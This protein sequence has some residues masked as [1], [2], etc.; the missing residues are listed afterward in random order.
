MKESL[1]ELLI[2]LWKQFWKKYKKIERN[3]WTFFFVSKENR[4]DFLNE[5]SN[6]FLK[7]TQEKF[8]KSF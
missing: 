8:Q 4:G 7:N 1:K 5:S 3:P 2:E 6:T